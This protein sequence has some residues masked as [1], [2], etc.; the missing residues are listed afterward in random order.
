MTEY[1][2][3]CLCGAVR[4]VIDAESPKGMFLCHCSRCR[5]ETGSMHCANA[6]F[7]GG[8]LRFEAGQEQLSFY[9]L[10]GTR[11]S[12]QFCRTCGSPV[13]RTAANGTIVLPAGTLD[14]T[15]LVSPTAH[16]HCDSQSAWVA[17]A[18]EAPRFGGFP[19]GDQGSR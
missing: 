15:S 9:A 14:D 6:F 17:T 8:T 11:K 5:R 1:R 16:I 3:K 4:Y 7:T 19:G 18:A 10:P 13:P 12:R 2:G